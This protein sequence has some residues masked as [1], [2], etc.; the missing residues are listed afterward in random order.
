MAEKIESMNLEQIE[1]HMAVI[2]KRAAA[3]GGHKS[4]NEIV[5][6]VMSVFKMKPKKLNSMTRIIEAS[7]KLDEQSLRYIGTHATDISLGKSVRV[8]RIEFP[9]A[10]NGMIRFANACKDAESF[11]YRF[12]SL[13]PNEQ[14]KIGDI[15]KL[16]TD[17]ESLSKKISQLSSV[18]TPKRN[19]KKR[20]TLRA[21]KEA[22]K[23]EPTKLEEAKKET[24]EVEK[25]TTAKKPTM[26]K[27]TTKKTEVTVEPKVTKET[28]TEKPTVVATSEA[29]EAVAK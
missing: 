12:S 19:N 26:A 15:T 28:T 7:E 10:K 20:K 16:F 2:A 13:K 18:K 11:M 3:L 25:T 1:K 24:V 21:S 29:K 9:W 6:I 8:P 23:E 14:G 17:A 22:N 4:D 27:T 5:D